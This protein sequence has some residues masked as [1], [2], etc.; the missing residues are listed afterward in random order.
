MNEA[1]QEKFQA[2]K[3]DVTS[4]FGSIG[5]YL[6]DSL[7]SS[8]EWFNHHVKSMFVSGKEDSTTI[9]DTKQDLK[10][11]GE[12]VKTEFDNFG[13]V[14]KEWGEN[15][16]ENVVDWGKGVKTYFGEFCQD[17]NKVFQA[18]FITVL[19][20]LATASI[21]EGYIYN[22]NDHDDTSSGEKE[23]GNGD[24]KEES[25]GED[26]VAAHLPMVIEE[27]ADH[28]SSG[29]KEERN[30]DKKEESNGEDTVDAH[31]PMVIEERVDH[32]SIA[33]NQESEEDED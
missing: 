15:L 25:S 27:R 11:F 26:T 6:K 17:K 2:M 31:L 33:E 7:Q 3:N 20:G 16:F 32:I 18:L 24:K 5:G 30:G 28:I 1:C 12:D 14:V 21:I 22:S 19:V 8:T 29:E 23:E 13:K 10:E 4:L 9:D